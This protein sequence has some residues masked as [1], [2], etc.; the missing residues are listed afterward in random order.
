MCTRSGDRA[1]RSSALLGLVLL[2]DGELNSG[3]P[4]EDNAV[5]SPT[6]LGLVLLVGGDV[7]GGGGGDEE[8]SEG[9][10]CD[11]VT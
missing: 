2:V 1:V 11:W 6:L 4:G 10:H 9:V 8:G 7:D 5:G 3:L